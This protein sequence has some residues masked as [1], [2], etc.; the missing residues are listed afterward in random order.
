MIGCGYRTSP[1][2]IPAVL[3]GASQAL[4]ATL[5][6]H[7]GVSAA[8]G[9]VLGSDLRRHLVQLDASSACGSG[10]WSW[11]ALF[12]LPAPRKTSDRLGCVRLHTHSLRDER[13]RR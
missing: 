13:G 10:P 6:R 7:G 8:Y 1:V 3:C 2:N 4:L 12:G 11:A 5:A 9:P